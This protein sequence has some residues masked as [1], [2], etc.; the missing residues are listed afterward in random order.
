MQP[1]TKW[2]SDPQHSEL[3]FKIKHLMISSVTGKFKKFEVRTETREID[4]ENS[5]INLTAQAASISTNNKK[6]DQHLL[7][8]DFFDT[9]QFSTL[10]FQSSQLERKGKHSFI[11]YGTLKMKGV[12]NKIK[13]LMKQSE[14]IKDPWGNERVGFTVEGE[15]NR[16]DWGLDYNAALETGGFV[17]GDKVAVHG[18]IQLVKQP[19]EV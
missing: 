14:I 11:L 1:S 13:L 18:D 5:R 19:Q 17:L 9:A 7:G 2:V 10:E 3:G 8:S 6:R 12:S 16:K 15:I 4:F